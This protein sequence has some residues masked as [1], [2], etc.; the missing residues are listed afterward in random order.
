MEDSL[1]HGCNSVIHPGDAFACK[2]SKGILDDGHQNEEGKHLKKKK[3]WMLNEMETSF[4]T[5][6]SPQ[7]RVW[8]QQ[9]HQ[10]TLSLREEPC[11]T[12]IEDDEEPKRVHLWQ[13]LQIQSQET[14]T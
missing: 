9:R 6:N 5:T 8:E 11:K 10:D 12:C 2:E 14:S 4:I 7:Q 1:E 3:K 13:S